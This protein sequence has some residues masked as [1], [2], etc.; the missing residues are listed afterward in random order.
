MLLTLITPTSGEISIFGY[1][2]NKHRKEILQ[3]IGAVIEK[4]DVYKY[5]S[6]YENLKLFAKLS[7][8]KPTNKMLMDQLEMVGLASRAHD[9]VKTFSQGMKQRLG[10][11]IALVH[12]PQLIILDEPTNGLDPQGI[13]DIR[14]LILILSREMKKTVIVSS[15]LL[16]EI[17]HIATRILIIDKGRKL[18]E[19]TS[20][21][22]FNDQQT[23]LQISVA[24]N[25][26]AIQTILASNWAI[27]LLP[28]RDGQI[29]VGLNKEDI[30]NFNRM[31]AAS[32]V[33]IYSLQARHSLEDYFLQ[34]TA[35]KQ[36]VGTFTN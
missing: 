24:N 6:A 31:L 22:L 3:Q 8:V 20:A 26:T 21:E 7:G 29:M 15:H 13:A 18:V 10:I 1:D 14:N 34:V 27:N 28:E 11:G 23:I 12:N 25:D 33:D 4:P 36:H 9:T 30:P 17:E 2:L 5:L 16:N 32:G 19:G 35:G